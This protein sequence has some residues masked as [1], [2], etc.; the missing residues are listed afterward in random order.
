MEFL[1]IVGVPAAF[2]LAIGVGLTYFTMQRRKRRSLLWAN[3]RRE[4]FL[5]AAR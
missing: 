1:A 4:A 5:S 2:A 3:R